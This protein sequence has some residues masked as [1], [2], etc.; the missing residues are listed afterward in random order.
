MSCL[1][2]IRSRPLGKNW[3]LIRV[4]AGWVVNNTSLKQTIESSARE[5][6][7]KSSSTTLAASVNFVDLAGSERASQALSAE[8]R[9]KEGCHINRSLL[10][11]GTVI[12]KLRLSPSF[13]AYGVYLLYSASNIVSKPT[14]GLFN[15]TPS[16]GGNSRT[17][18]ICTLSPARSHVEQTRNTLLFACC[19][20]QV[21]TKA[22]V[23]VVM[24]DKV[25]VK[26]LQ[27]EVARL[28]SELRTPCP[29]STNCDCAAM[30][31]KKNL[32]IQKMEREIRELIEQ[33][34]LAQSQIE[35]LM[36]MVGNG[37]KSRKN[38]RCCK[39]IQSVELEESS[40]DDLEYADP[41]VSNNGVLALTLYGEENV[42]SQEIPTPVNEDREEKQNQLTYGV[43]EQRLDDSQLS[44]DSPMTMSETVP[45]CRNLKLLR[46]WSCREYYTSSSPEKAGG[47][48]L[49][50]IIVKLLGKSMGYVPMKESLKS[51]WNWPWFLFGQV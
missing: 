34:H 3:S 36:C 19:A 4:V 5:F 18:I 47:P 41:S 27:K 50:A 38:T 13:L 32:Q 31:R 35:D 29:P 14:S 17:S 7:G 30:L 26:Q 22:Q 6:M 21:T 11:L 20:K 48:W 51:V 16:L 25:L 12:R 2:F 15:S 33:R 49:D 37:Q 23:N 45:N 39:E 42:I 43:L 44:N 28:E 24:S 8:S 46:S 10:T 9:L 40:R 1:Q